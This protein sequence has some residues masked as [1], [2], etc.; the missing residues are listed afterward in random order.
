MSNSIA[1]DQIKDFAMYIYI[2]M[3]RWDAKIEL[4]KKNRDGMLG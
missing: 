4:E 1:P 3:D 2:Y